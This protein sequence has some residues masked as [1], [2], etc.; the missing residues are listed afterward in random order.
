MRTAGVVIL[1]LL[2]AGCQQIS[3]ECSADAVINRGKKN[4][5]ANPSSFPH[6]SPASESER[7]SAW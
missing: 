4:R 7:S 2:L 3:M 1:L 5:L 6:L